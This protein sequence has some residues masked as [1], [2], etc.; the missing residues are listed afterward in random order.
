MSEI[1][2]GPS[3]SQKTILVVD[4]DRE[5]LGLVSNYLCSL[6]YTETV[7]RMFGDFKKKK[8]IEVKGATVILR[9]KGAHSRRWSLTSS[10]DES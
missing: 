7:T 9:N 3:L 2:R 6:G 4:D 8:L 10:Y 5:I 1:D